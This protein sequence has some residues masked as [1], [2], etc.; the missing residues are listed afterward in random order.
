MGC[1]ASAVHAGVRFHARMCIWAVALPTA[2]GCGVTLSFVWLIA[3]AKPT[4]AV[5]TLQPVLYAQQRGY[6]SADDGH[7]DARARQRLQK[8]IAKRVI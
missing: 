8:N 3:A 5:R 4:G 6:T 7:S 1:D 2:F